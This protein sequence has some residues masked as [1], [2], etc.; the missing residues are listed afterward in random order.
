MEK[1]SANDLRKRFLGYFEKNGHQ[2]VP[3]DSLVPES[4]PTLLF[5]GA[6]MNQ[7]KDQFLGTNITYT[8]AATCQKC[9]RIGD[10]DVVGTTAAHHTFFEML[11][12]FSFGDYFKEGAIEFAWKFFVDELRIPEERLF[13]SIFED[14]DEAFEIW[15]KKVGVPAAKVFRSSA[16]DNFWPSNAITKG[17]NGPCGPCSE[18]YFDTQR[19][20][21]DREIPGFPKGAFHP[22]NRR[23]VEVWNLVFTGYNRSG[24]V[25]GAGVLEPLPSQNIDTG[26]GFERLLAVLNGHWSNFYTEVFTPIISKIADLSGRG[27]NQVKYVGEG[28]KKLDPWEYDTPDGTRMRRIA[29]HARAATFCLAD[30]VRPG[31]VGREYVLRKIIRRAVRDGIDL[32]LEEPFLGELVP[33]IA[34]IMK[35]PY[36]EIAQQENIIRNRLKA[37]EEQFRR[38]I[39]KGLPV[40]RDFFSLYLAKSGEEAV[41]DDD[42]NLETPAATVPA[43]EVYKLYETHGIPFD[44]QKDLAEQEFGLAL[45][46][47]EWKKFL[48]SRKGEKTTKAD[49]FAE[50]PFDHLRR[51]EPP[52]E[53]EGYHRTRIRT[54]ILGAFWDERIPCLRKWN[55]AANNSWNVNPENEFDDGSGYGGGISSGMGSDDG[56]GWGGPEFLVG[57]LKEVFKSR[58]VAVLLRKSPFYAEGGGEVGDVGTLRA[59]DFEAEVLDTQKVDDYFLHVCRV[60]KGQLRVGS[61]IEASVDEKRRAAIT[62]NHT[63][64]HILHNVIRGHDPEARQAGSLVRD[65][66]LRFDVEIFDREKLPSIDRIEREVNEVILGNHEVEWSVGS[67]DDAEAKGVIMFF[68]EKYGD[69]VRTVRIRDAHDQTVSAELCGGCHVSATGDIGSFRILSMSAIGAN[70]I[71]VTAVTGEAAVESFQRDREILAQLQSEFKATNVEEVLPKLRKLAEEA[72][73]Q[74]KEIE[75]L[76]SDVASGSVSA[77]G[78]GDVFEHHG[79]KIVTR[80]MDEDAAKDLGSIADNMRD[81]NAPAM[82]MLGAKTSKGKAT[83]VLSISPELVQHKNLDASKLIESAATLIGGRG[84]GKK[85]FAQAGG[86]D[87][88]KLEAALNAFRAAVKQLKLP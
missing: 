70:V 27:P 6:G 59:K 51:K 41:R 50:G 39:Q 9:L 2:I 55:D 71:R 42:G 29:D 87:A 84:G 78:A 34:K 35:E 20:E 73:T 45:D 18:I 58:V 28:G 82:V 75:K 60:E 80:I 43:A 36:K 83:L 16:K 1:I 4:D 14:D 22:D 49:V 79:V 52:T 85:G 23:Y 30:G 48:A 17:P 81:A 57:P 38:T 61:E 37:E 67:K 31:K 3:S 68:G 19:A 5:T 62:R 47:D 33:T 13:V 66:L 65:D 24:P 72:K 12:N 88:D 15:T 54:Q 10:L 26:M 40:V 11:G 8:R 69:E 21:L 77:G 64:T 25:P 56:S 63:A 7:F 76:R 44:F 53:F 74:R 32:G 46:D 86:K